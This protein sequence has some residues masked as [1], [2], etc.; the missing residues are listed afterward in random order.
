MNTSD[1]RKAKTAKAGKKALFKCIYL[2]WN[3]RFD[4]SRLIRFLYDDF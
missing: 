3:N 4:W 2:W 1:C